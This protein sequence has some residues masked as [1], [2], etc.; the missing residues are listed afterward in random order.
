[1]EA[2]RVVEIGRIEQG[3]EWALY[4]K[5]GAAQGLLNLPLGAIW[6]KVRSGLEVPVSKIPVAVWK[7]R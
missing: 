2:S 4:V 3:P 7:A 5:I 1:M 6:S